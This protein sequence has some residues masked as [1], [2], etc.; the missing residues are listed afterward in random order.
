MSKDLIHY[1][2]WKN[3]GYEIR[4]ENVVTD[5][6]PHK[7]I[8]FSDRNAKDVITPQRVSPY[9]Q[10]PTDAQLILYKY[11]QR[12]HEREEEPHEAEIMEIYLEHTKPLNKHRF[13][14]NP[15][16]DDERIHRIARAWYKRSVAALVFLGYFGLQFKRKAV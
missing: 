13:T 3:K 9:Y 1:E 4:I 5:L 2:E 11:L 6:V 12:K 10:N 7:K 14:T 15:E 16:A 8:E